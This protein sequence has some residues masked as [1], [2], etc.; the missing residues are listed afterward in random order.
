MISQY[1]SDPATRHYVVTPS[2]TTPQTPTPRALCAQSNGIIS[3]TDDANT[4]I[5]YTV[6]TGQILPFR[7]YIITTATTANVAAWY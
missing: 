7:A 1:G 5:S 4:T 6:V 2:N 3:I